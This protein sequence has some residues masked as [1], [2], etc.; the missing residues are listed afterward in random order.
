MVLEALRGLNGTA[1][2]LILMAAAIENDCLTREY[3]DAA[4]KASEIY[5]LASRSDLVLDLAFPA[6]NL[7]GEIIMHGGPYDRTAL[8]REGPAGPI[9]ADQRG[10]VWQ[11]P[12]GWDFGHLDYFPGGPLDRIFAPPVASPV[13]N[14]PVPID[15]PPN[16]WKPSWSAGAMSTQAE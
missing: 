14:A 2:R 4:A 7:V 12:D 6:G 8:G 10:G 9:P 15:P 5:I 1:R 11:I 16:N 13:G 3:A